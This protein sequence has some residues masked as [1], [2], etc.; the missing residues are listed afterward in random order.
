MQTHKDAQRETFPT[1]CV[2]HDWDHEE[3]EKKIPKN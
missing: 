2:A 1:A 3:E